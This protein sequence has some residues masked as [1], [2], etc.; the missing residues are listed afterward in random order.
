M[1]EQVLNTWILA[2]LAVMALLGSLV[3]SLSSRDPQWFGRA[4]SIA[5]V[6]GLL[7]TVKH[8]I[9][10]ASRDEAEVVHEKQHWAKWAPANDSAEYQAALVDAKRVIRDE[11]LGLLITVLGTAVWGYGELLL[12]HLL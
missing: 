11:Y 7:L 3:L 8:S 6:C 10:S 1:R 4:G 9:L 2:G 12:G 5:T